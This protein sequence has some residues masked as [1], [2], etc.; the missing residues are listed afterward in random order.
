LERI[1]GI[2]FGTTNSLA[3]YITNQGEI[4]IIKDHSG[5][6]L[7]PSVV[8]KYENKLY[9]GKEA[10]ENIIAFNDGYGIKEIKREIGLGKRINFAGQQ[11]YP[12][13]IA[14]IILKKIKRN[15]ELLFG[16]EVDQ[17]VITVPAEFSDGQR[18]EIIEAGIIA[19]FDVKKII[20]EPTAAVMAY[21]F[22]KNFNKT[23]LCYDFGGE[24]LIFPLPR[25]TIMI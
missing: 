21:S 3:A 17:A 18:K 19:G 8:C 4:K 11:M 9:V 20:N 12:Y 10:K 25:L 1:I 2:D 16:N 7:T 23:I 15:A 14:A 13:E 22:N 6:S 24:H 5:D